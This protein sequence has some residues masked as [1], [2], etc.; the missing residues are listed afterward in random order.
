MKQT[1][2]GIIDTKGDRHQ[3]NTVKDVAVT[4][5]ARLNKVSE[6]EVLKCK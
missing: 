1:V 2:I 3:R 6:M 4:K 5:S